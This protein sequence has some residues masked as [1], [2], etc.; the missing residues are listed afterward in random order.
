MGVTQETHA[1]ELLP[2]FNMGEFSDSPMIASASFE[3]IKGTIDNTVSMRVLTVPRPVHAHSCF[4]W[5]FWKQ[6]PPLP[7]ETI[8]GQAA[9]FFSRYPMV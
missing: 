4:C 9:G 5:R 6:I 2:Y 8:K 7:M 3:L 1:Q